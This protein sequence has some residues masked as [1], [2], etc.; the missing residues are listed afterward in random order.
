MAFLEN[1]SPIFDLSVGRTG[2]DAVRLSWKTRIKDLQTM[3]DELVEKA[4]A[5]S[6]EE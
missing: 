6:R 3:L 4:R 2:K 5:L 1:T